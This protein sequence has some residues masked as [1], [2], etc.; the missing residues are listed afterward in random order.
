MHPHHQ[1]KGKHGGAVPVLIHIVNLL[2]EKLGVVNGRISAVYF[3]EGVFITG[4]GIGSG[5]TGAVV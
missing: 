4:I 1:L 5:T 2:A 3:L